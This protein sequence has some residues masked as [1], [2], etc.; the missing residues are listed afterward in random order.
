[1][2][3]R[4]IDSGKQF[5]ALDRRILQR[6]DFN[7]LVEMGLDRLAHKTIEPDEPF[8][9]I[10]FQRCVEPSR[11][12]AAA[13]GRKPNE[14]VLL[15]AEFHHHIGIETNAQPRAGAE[16]TRQMIDAHMGVR[17]PVVVIVLG[18]LIHECRRRLLLEVGRILDLLQI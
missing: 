18:M 5:H 11:H 4:H 15:Q 7:R 13:V 17:R 12:A 10:G 14:I 16:R 6:L 9:S 2:R 8:A 3:Q 1:M